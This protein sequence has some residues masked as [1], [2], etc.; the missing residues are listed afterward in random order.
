MQLP[1]PTSGSVRF[2]GV[3]LTDLKGETLRQIRPRMQM[4]FQDPI[5]SLNPRRTVHDIVGEPLRIWSKAAKAERAAKIDEVLDAV[6]RR[7][8]DGAD[9]SAPRVLRRAV[10]ARL[11]RPRRRHRS[12]ADHL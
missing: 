4:I 12:A 2:E 10:P 3:E 6:G 5:S 11:D 1:Q 9:P 8:E 7:S